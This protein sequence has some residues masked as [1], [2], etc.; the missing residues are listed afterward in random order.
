MAIDPRIALGIEGPPNLGRSLG[1][2]L[3]LASGIQSLQ[4]NVQKRQQQQEANELLTNIIPFF[5]GDD[6]SG[7]A[8]AI[9]ASSVFDEDDKRELG[10][11]V[12]AFQQGNKKPML[13]TIAQA[14][15]ALGTTGGQGFTLGAGQT[16]F[17]PSGNVIASVEK[18]E[19]QDDKQDLELLKLQ[20]KRTD[21]R[22][23]R[24]QVLRSEIDTLSKDFFQVEDA[25]DRIKNSVTDPS[26]AGDLAMVFNFMKLLDPGSVVRESEFATAAQARA[27]LSEQE[28]LGV[29]VP[30]FVTQAIQKFDVGTFLT[31]AQRKDFQGRAK[32]IFGGA[33]RIHDRR[34][35]ARLSIG[36]Q[37]GVK[38]SLLL[39]LPPVSGD[40]AGSVLPA[41]QPP[42]VPPPAVIRFDAEGNPIQ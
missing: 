7:A 11:A 37:F 31:P 35:D 2:G 12:Q 19:K 24:A 10:K 36:E 17:G 5:E 13:A 22:F 38:K 14:N 20:L 29:R 32:K 40:G 3:N 39:G 27:W 6:A 41:V 25:F 8:A 34:V 15:R 21:E 23:D 18:E 33:E 42:A 30:S 28:T 26:P 4:A 16:R 1:R 9:E